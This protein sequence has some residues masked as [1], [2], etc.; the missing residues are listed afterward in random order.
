M[1]GNEGQLRAVG[2]GLAGGAHQGQGGGVGLSVS[3]LTCDFQSPNPP[4]MQRGQMVVGDG[5]T[6]PAL[7]GHQ[8][9]WL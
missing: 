5:G 1:K 2:A 4:Q 6:P 8:P 9:R 3:A 7:M